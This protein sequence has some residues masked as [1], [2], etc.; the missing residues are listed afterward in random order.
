MILAYD[1]GTG[2]IKASLFDA[3]G[4]CV[5]S[6]FDAYPTL[7]PGTGLHEQRPADWW[8]ATVAATHGLTAQLTPEQRKSI[9]AIGISGHSLG[10]VPVDAA[11]NLLRETV[12][13]WSDSRAGAEAAEFFA[14]LGGAD[15]A[16]RWYARTGCGFPPGLYTVFKLMWFR[17][18]EPEWFARAHRILGT[19]DWVNFRLCGVMATDN[20]YA[21]GSGVY[22]L[23]ARRYDPEL[24]AASGL[25]PALFPEI[26]PSAQV[27]GPLT[28]A[29]AAELGLA[30]DVVVTAGGVDNSCMALGAGAWCE[31][32]AY[33]SLG[34]SSWIAVSSAEPILDPRTRPYVFDHVVPGQ[35]A[36]ALAIF[37]AG[38]SHTWCRDQLCRDLLDDPRGAYAA[39]DA[40]AAAAGLG[41]HGLFFNPTLAGGSSLDATPALR[42]A[43]ANLD[44]RHTRGDMIRAVME[45]VAFGLRRALDALDAL[46]P[47]R[48]PLVLVGGGAKVSLGR[49]IYADVYGRRVV[50]AEIGQQAAALGAAVTAGV[51]CGLW[52]DYSVV[53]SFTGLGDEDAPDP[54]RQAAYAAL[55]ARYCALTDHLAVWSA[56]AIP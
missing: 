16:D 37:S 41:A 39:M 54:A 36:S 12:P 53:D 47:V 8:H 43:F 28:A 19:K 3:Q 26:V 9:R 48:E 42:G 35:Y 31:G 38:T 50:R 32:R 25:P 7:Y 45:G 6:G 44:L 5:A 15:P 20:S 49:R 24:V 2:G 10:V 14:A 33:N 34:S 29:A 51:G 11:G 30:R 23:R 17:R 4:R 21:S 1:F 40:E 13:I 46:C 18:H 22:D 55:Y 52:S 56:A 27:L